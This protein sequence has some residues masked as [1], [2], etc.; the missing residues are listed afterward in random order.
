MSIKIEFKN[1]KKRNKMMKLSLKLKIWN[2]DDDSD[3]IVE[4][5]VDLNNLENQNTE[6]EDEKQTSLICLITVPPFTSSLVFFDIWILTIMKSVENPALFLS[7]TF[8][9]RHVSMLDLGFHKD[10]NYLSVSSNFSKL[11]ELIIITTNYDSF[12][13][14]TTHSKNMWESFGKWAYD[15]L[16]KPSYSLKNQIENDCALF[17]LRSESGVEKFFELGIKNKSK[18]FSKFQ[19]ARNNLKLENSKN[20]EFTV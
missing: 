4:N 5:E 3:N 11:D 10:M 14:T 8:N 12:S 19:I 2:E 7:A 9:S 1:Y 6:N 16:K 18:Y 13:K 17:F 20:E 15:Y